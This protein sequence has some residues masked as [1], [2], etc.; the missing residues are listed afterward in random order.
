MKLQISHAVSAESCISFPV[1]N[2]FGILMSRFFLLSHQ[3]MQKRKKNVVSGYWMLHLT[4]FYSK[5]LYW[6]LEKLKSMLK[7]TGLFERRADGRSKVSPSRTPSSIFRHSGDGRC[8]PS[9]SAHHLLLTEARPDCVI[10]AACG[11]VRAWPPSKSLFFCSRVR[12]THHKN[13]SD[14]L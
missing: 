5:S 6:S 13:T 4:L 10:L 9:V 11:K 1:I 7:A 2:C 3:I 8:H 12:L 14:F